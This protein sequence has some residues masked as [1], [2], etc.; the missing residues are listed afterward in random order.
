[1]SILAR[2]LAPNFTLGELVASDT[3]KRLGDQNLPDLE[4]LLNLVELARALQ[5][6]RAFLGRPVYVTSAFRN[7]RVNTAVGG[8][9][10]S[11]HALGYAADFKVEGL[12]LM[13]AANEI[14]S[15]RRAGNL[16]L[17]WDQLILEP[18][19]CVHLSVD[20]RA[21]GQ[22]LTQFKLGGKVYA[23]LLASE[24]GQ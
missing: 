14:V 4:Q 15:G 12:T 17:K 7:R 8:V 2:R 21:R 9:A 3:A 13:Q 6:V 19:R 18:G 23:G 22:V 24:P 20:P 11:A 1:M 5:S 10:T 16:P